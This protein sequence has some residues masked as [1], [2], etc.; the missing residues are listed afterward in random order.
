MVGTVITMVIWSISFIFNLY[1]ITENTRFRCDSP[2]VT[3]FLM[4]LIAPLVTTIC[5]THFIT[6]KMFP[7]IYKIINII[8]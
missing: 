4:L 7:E 5:I 6:R 1:Y 3:C 2:E 8:Y